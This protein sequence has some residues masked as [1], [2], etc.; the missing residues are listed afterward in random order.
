MEHAQY[1]RR[2]LDRCVTT[3]NGIG[4]DEAILD[5]LDRKC[6]G[7]QSCQVIVGAVHLDT[8]LECHGDMKLSLLASFVCV[9]RE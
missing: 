8:S 6:S 3:E 2:E 5:Q 9:P 1:G 4:C 7:Q